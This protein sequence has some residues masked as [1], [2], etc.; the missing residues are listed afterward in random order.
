[1]VKFV[2][3]LVNLDPI[4]AQFEQIVLGI[5][6]TWN[7]LAKFGICHRKNENI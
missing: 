4:K 7:H 3:V 2:R 6:N 1:M 5:S